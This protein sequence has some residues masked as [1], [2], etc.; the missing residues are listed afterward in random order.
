MNKKTFRART[1]RNCGWEQMLIFLKNIWNDLDRETTEDQI[2]AY[3][4]FF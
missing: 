1:E 4:G 2:G 3:H